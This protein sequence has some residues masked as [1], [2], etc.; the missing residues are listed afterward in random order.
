MKQRDYFVGNKAKGRISKWVFL[1]AKHTKISEKQTFLT[2]F[3][4]IT[5]GYFSKKKF[6][7]KKYSWKFNKRKKSRKKLEQTIIE[8]N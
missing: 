8:S 3:C 5:D 1:K 7:Q 6:S 4:F 2:P